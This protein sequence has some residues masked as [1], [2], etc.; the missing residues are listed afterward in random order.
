MN[1]NAL[2]WITMT[3]VV[4]FPSLPSF[5]SVAKAVAQYV[6]ACKLA[7]NGIGTF[8]ANTVQVP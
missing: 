8:P 1:T 6:S 3:G 5:M 4:T 7:A 2:P